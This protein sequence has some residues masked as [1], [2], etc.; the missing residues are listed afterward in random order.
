VELRAAF[1]NRHFATERVGN[2]LGF[3]VARTLTENA[4]F[5][6]AIDNTKSTADRVIAYV[7]RGNAYYNKQDYGRAIENF[8][9]A[10]KL[11]PKYF[12]AYNYRGKTYSSRGEN[13]YAIT[14]FSQAIQLNPVYVD[15][16]NNR[17]LAYK[18]VGRKAEAIADFRKAQSIDPSDQ[19]SKAQ[20][21]NL[22]G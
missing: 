6:N 19:I 14:D 7:E 10:I 5:A 17:G 2:Y 1:R 12:Q 20:L 21:R 18:A 4:E 3:R 13:N 22:G 8:S 16:Y 11:D 9:E 15:A